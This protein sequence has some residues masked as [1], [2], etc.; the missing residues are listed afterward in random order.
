MI[1]FATEPGKQSYDGDEE[2][3][4]FTSELLKHLSQPDLDIFQLVDRIDQGLEDRGFKQPPYL[5]GRLRG[6][7]MFNAN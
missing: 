4:L 7:F 6:R 2:N 5:E 1:V 3:G